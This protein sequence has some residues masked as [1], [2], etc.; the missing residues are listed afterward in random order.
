MAHGICFAATDEGQPLAV[1]DVTHPAFAV[2]ATDAELAKLTEQFVI[3]QRQRGAMTEPVREI[4][5]RSLLGRGITASEGT[6]MTGLN[7]Y[8]RKLGPGNLPSEA[9]EIDRRIAE[10]FPVLAVRLRVQDMARLLA[11]GLLPVL[12]AAPG[13]P[14]ALVN[15]AGGPAADSWNA[16]IHLR[17]ER[18]DVVD[19]R[20]ITIAVL[21]MDDRGAAFGAR[22]VAALEAPGAPLAG[23]DVAFQRIAYD[24]SDTGALARALDDV[25]AKDS[26]CGVSSEGG[27]FEYGSDAAIVANLE[28]LHA[29]TPVEAIIAGSA[30]RDAEPVRASQAVSRAVT[31]P[32]TLGAFTQLVERAGW[33]VQ[34]A[35]ERPFSY[36]VRLAKR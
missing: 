17:R 30:T 3:E 34:R 27:L 31:Q 16:L 18:P 9:G 24:W 23:L 10:S 12:A 15:I 32:R 1:V 6:F 20:A 19:A 36:N 29:G 25:R 28:V 26:V 5:R 8:L 7:T 33:N 2:S 21:D 13:R 4:L 14:L 35:I 22:A 11:D